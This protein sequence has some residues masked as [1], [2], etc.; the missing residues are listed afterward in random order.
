MMRR[1][2]SPPWS[3]VVLCSAAMTL[4]LWGA[5]LRADVDGAAPKPIPG[6]LGRT[7]DAPEGVGIH[8]FPP[9]PQPD[10][11]FK[12]PSTITD[13]QGVLALAKLRGTGE[14]TDTRTGIK[15]PAGFEMDM[16]LMKG[17]YIGVDGIEHNGVFGF[18]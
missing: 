6:G 1:W 13:F 4:V 11:S 12:D 10:G 18:I 14:A 17:R 15:Y 2:R 5:P 16:R 3:T 8:F 7:A 9:E